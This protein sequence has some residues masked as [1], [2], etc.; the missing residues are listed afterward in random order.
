MK[1]IFK[2]IITGIV[3]LTLLVTQG[4]P[5]CA[6]SVTTAPSSSVSTLPAVGEMISLSPQFAPI[7]LKGIQLHQDNPFLLSFIVADQE[8][9]GQPPVSKDE[10]ARLIKYF[11][12]ALTTPKEDLWVNLSPYER[13]RIAPT[14]F[15]QTDMGRDLL[16]QDYLLKQLTSSLMYPEKAFGKEFWQQLYARAYAL[17]GT[18]DIPI[19]TFNKVWIVPDKAVVYERDDAAF[20]GENHLR[21]LLEED[22]LSLKE[23]KQDQSS[24]TKQLSTTDADKVNQVSSQ[25]VR[26]LVVP[27]LEKEVNEGKNFALLRQIYH[28]VILATWF[29]EKQKASLLGHLYVN[30]N[31]VAGVE[32]DDPAI[33]EKIFNQYVESFK[34]GAYN[35]VKEEYDPYRAET[36]PR[37]YF[38]GGAIM[39]PDIENRPLS[40]MPGKDIHG[41]KVDVVASPIPQN[42]PNGKKIS[43]ATAL[44]FSLV[45]SLTNLAQT[46]ANEI[47]SPKD[48]GQPA[49]VQTTDQKSPSVV[50]T[51][52]G[53]SNP[54]DSQYQD[55]N[56]EIQGLGPDNFSKLLNIYGNERMRKSIEENPYLWSKR[57]KMINEFGMDNFVW[58]VDTFGTER[59][60]MI[61]SPVWSDL[62]CLPELKIW[63]MD[64][65]KCVTVILGEDIVRKKIINTYSYM[66]LPFIALI[67]TFGIDNLEKLSTSI[68]KERLRI[69][70]LNNYVLENFLRRIMEKNVDLA[71]LADF[72]RVLGDEAMNQLVRPDDIDPINLLLNIL[73]NFEV[74]E[75]ERIIKRLGTKWL[76]D[77]YS[78]EIIEFF[79]AVKRTGVANFEEWA[80]WI[81]LD[82]SQVEKRGHYSYLNIFIA[83]ADFG[84]ERYQRVVHLFGDD[85]IRSMIRKDLE[86]RFSF[87]FGGLLQIARLFSMDD[88]E[89]IAVIIGPQRIMTKLSS[90]DIKKLFSFVHQLGIDNFT[91]MVDVLGREAF[92]VYFTKEYKFSDFMESLTCINMQDFLTLVHTIGEVRMT[93]IFKQ[94]VDATK[95]F[96]DMVVET[97]IDKFVT[98]KN[99]LDGDFD[100]NTIRT[101]QFLGLMKAYHRWGEHSSQIVNDLRQRFIKP[102]SAGDGER[103]VKEAYLKKLVILKGQIGDQLF[104]DII[105]EIE[106]ALNKKVDEIWSE[107][108]DP[109]YFENF[110]ELIMEIHRLTKVFSGPNNPHIDEFR[111]QMTRLK[112]LFNRSDGRLTTFQSDFILLIEKVQIIGIDNVE[113]VIQALRAVYGDKKIAEFFESVDQKNKWVA[114]WR[115]VELVNRLGVDEFKALVTLVDKDQFWKEFIDD[116]FIIYQDWPKLVDQASIAI[117]QDIRKQCPFLFDVDGVLVNKNNNNF[118]EVKALLDG[119]AN[120]DELRKK[121]PTL[122]GEETKKVIRLYSL[123]VLALLPRV[124]TMDQ[125]TYNSIQTAIFLKAYLH[126]NYSN[127]N[128]SLEFGAEFMD[129]ASVAHELGHNMQPW[130]SGRGPLAEFGADLYMSAVLKLLGKE[131]EISKQQKI[132]QYVESSLLNSFG[133]EVHTVARAQFQW[134]IEGFKRT[135]HDIDYAVL[136]QVAD[137]ILQNAPRLR[138][139]SAFADFIEEFV[140]EYLLEKKMINEETARRLRENE[141]IDKKE[142]AIW[143]EELDKLFILAGLRPTRIAAAE[144]ANLTQKEILTKKVEEFV[145]MMPY[146]YSV[147]IGLQSE[148]KQVMEVLLRFHGNEVVQVDKFLD[149]LQEVWLREKGDSHWS[150]QQIHEVLQNVLIQY[151]GMIKVLSPEDMKLL[152]EKIDEFDKFDKSWERFSPAKID[153]ILKFIN[154]HSASLQN[155][156]QNVTSVLAAL[157]ISE[158]NP[159]QWVAVLGSIKSFGID[160]FEKL[161]QNIGPQR[162][163][164]MSEDPDVFN[165]FLQEIT[166]KK[167]DLAK[168]GNF[169]KILGDEAM[170]KFV[171]AVPFKF[172]NMVTVFEVKEFESITQQLGAQWIS[173]HTNTSLYFVGFIQD[174]YKA[175]ADFGI[176][177]FERMVRI[178]GEAAIRTLM[179]K[180]L[181]DYSEGFNVLLQIA[182][183]FAMDDFA[184]I[185][186]TLGP[187]R[188]LSRLGDSNIESF[189]SFVQRLGVQN[190]V[191]MVE[192]LGRETF[193]N[194]FESAILSY[195]IDSIEGL[196]CMDLNGFLSLANA[197]GQNNM[198][199]IFKNSR[200]ESFPKIIDSA[201]KMGID[202]FVIAKNRLDHD[203]DH[204]AI[205]HLIEQDTHLFLKLI[206]AYHRWGE[207]SSE[208]VN[209]LR[210]RFFRPFI[211][212]KQELEFMDFVAL[213]G[214]IGDALFEDIISELGPLKEYEHRYTNWTDYRQLISDIADLVNGL[215]SNEE[216]RLD[217]FR[218][219]VA[220]LRQIFNRPVGRLAAPPDFFWMMENVHSLGIDHIK[221]IVTELRAI[222]GE[223]TINKF[224]DPSR[225]ENG[226]TFWGLVELASRLGPDDFKLLIDSVGK[227]Q[228]W[229]EFTEK[230]D[231]IDHIFDLFNWTQTISTSSAQVIQEIKNEHPYL[232]YA[233]GIID[234]HK[235]FDDIKNLLA[236]LPSID[237]LR[238]KDPS[239][240]EKET[241]K[242]IRLYI[243][244]TLALFPRVVTMDVATYNAIQTAIILKANLKDQYA[245]ANASFEFGNEFL[246]IGIV[247]H[248]LG[249]NARAWYSQPGAPL[250]EFGGDLHMFAVLR[251]LGMEDEIVKQQ[252]LLK[253]LE[254][255]ELKSLGGEHHTVAR[256]QFQWLIE[257]FKRLGHEIDYAVLPQI[258]DDILQN[259]PR[260]RDPSAFA[261]FIKEF[262]IEY[263]VKKK[264][265]NQKTAQRL[266]DKE[267]ITTKENS[268]WPQQLDEMFVLAGLRP[269]RIS[270]AELANLTQKERLTKKVEEFVSMMPYGHSADAYFNLELQQ[271]MEVILRFHENETVQVDKFLDVLQEVWMKEIGVSDLIKSQI[272]EIFQKVLVQYFGK[273][274]V[275]S[276]ENMELLKTKIN[277]FD[278]S[279]KSDNSGEEISPAKIDLILKFLKEHAAAPEKEKP[280]IDQQG[281]VEEGVDDQSG[282]IFN[283]IA[284]KNFKSWWDS[285]NKSGGVY[286]FN[287][288]GA[289]FAI[290]YEN[291]K[292]VSFNAL[293]S[294]YQDTFPINQG[295]DAALFGKD[296]QAVGSDEVQSIA[297]DVTTPGGIDMGSLFLNL[298]VKPGEQPL[299]LPFGFAQFYN[300]P[301]DG[302][303]SFI[304]DMRPYSLQYSR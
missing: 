301:I 136:P 240:T 102:S 106:L 178:F 151:F 56:K 103:T 252:K 2:K 164:K 173:N 48:S 289:D 139:Q 232:F 192:M 299:D 53:I 23:N 254:F 268:I 50:G 132:F 161:A 278:K 172:L 144:L 60:W 175:I 135:G 15:G 152:K 55:L 141:H 225:G 226:V 14:E 108:S 122:Q 45:L 81:E 44:I 98:T 58:L 65:L 119:L 85:A 4:L 189:F 126:E 296:L 104:E 74:G 188:V 145:S 168:I 30:Q 300:M 217:E 129:I 146:G 255:S 291:G 258:A 91:M 207:Q 101:D 97:G 271:L 281:V 260:L 148:L 46:N 241:K 180:M 77:V 196:T 12:A 87:D 140:I 64:N 202:Q 25:V 176:E 149:V 29:K 80:D 94:D 163:R 283:N 158:A 194:R 209:D 99:R 83:I 238:K 88:F 89:K 143:P 303:M 18:T 256:A 186:E 210:Q 218:G 166:D 90:P 277:E 274:K 248:E 279:D 47:P 199:T 75:F 206:E 127:A 76:V 155:D 264:L 28:S 52:L 10:A 215:S 113:K 212:L 249:H 36:I 203:F 147:G 84:A 124:V 110:V 239:L 213:K 295:R 92:Q 286:R 159:D 49:I 221:K 297:G 111:E 138:N 6:Q 137:D 37:K 174:I 181:E 96:I 16:A 251:L 187:Q 7:V 117:I 125:A 79:Q 160:K 1:I 131:T 243:L 24:S 234:E 304:I 242:V 179:D 27:A 67:D 204:N 266:R 128:S 165:K 270:A 134:L 95:N 107:S 219:I 211:D 59:M 169:S 43:G 233:Q 262:V 114:F 153:F 109:N 261:D 39:N 61:I 298:D 167:I 263:L 185:V 17:Y 115:M 265:I 116:T 222:F 68:G 223:D 183:P 224:Y 197:V 69:I 250:S 105:G 70:S 26:D 11:F 112:H 208:I 205:L 41:T 42:N 19:N 3:I 229:K 294:V 150:K 63:G 244:G 33:K 247:A 290:I 157:G 73:E 54:D 154:E 280:G 20:V 273:I 259:D 21:V 13:D 245:N 302:V 120:I 38:S 71:K 288:D 287:Y 162:L 191:A 86:N 190:F 230:G 100:Q 32:T 130:Y 9:D 51:L 253:Y 184:K 182:R 171:E 200:S 34:K 214:K 231:R 276:P 8:N 293:P 269:T 118:N 227:D 22:Y 235:Y 177:R 40:A 72:S 246:D 201:N 170:S 5:A 133:E 220:R 82:H 31:K 93:E 121:D 236:G 123:G 228:F 156:D 62:R 142:N 292:A 275:L 272:H 66:R 237:E 284:G 257:G 285:G 78:E 195:L 57:L 267:V 35:Y 282:V 198:M 216:S 193:C